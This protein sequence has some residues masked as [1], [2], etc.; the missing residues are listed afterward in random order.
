MRWR[1]PVV[2]AL[3]AAVPAV[4]AEYLQASGRL[5]LKQ[6]EGRAKLV[7]VSDAPAPVLPGADPRTVGAT[8]RVVGADQDVTV[9]LPAA[10]WTL[11]QAG[12]AYAFANPGA[13]GGSSPVRSAR[14]RGGNVVKIVAADSLIDLDDDAQ[15]AISVVLTVG[16][17]AY[18]AECAAPRVDEPGEFVARRCAAPAACPAPAV[19]PTFPVALGDCLFASA[20]CEDACMPGPIRLPLDADTAWTSFFAVAN[21][22]NVQSYVPG[23]CGGGLV[24]PQLRTGDVINLNDGISTGVLN[25]VACTIAAGQ[26][27]FVVPVV[28]CG[29]EPSSA[30]TG[31]AAV[32]LDEVITGPGSHVLLHAVYRPA[33]PGQPGSA[34]CP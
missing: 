30:V 29:D 3:V 17:S 11:N 2:L 31:F 10:G 34:S 32:V 5:V 8:L 4:A 24:P 13:P 18:C 21:I 22:A 20:C 9:P 6:R 26:T 28:A 23:P 15:G 1:L 19:T 27:E 16:G 7:W 25:D 33:L 14:L 12:T